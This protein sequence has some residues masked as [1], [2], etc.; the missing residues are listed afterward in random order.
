MNANRKTASTVGALYIIGTVAGILSLVVTEPVRNAEDYLVTIPGN[1]T[2]LAAGAFFVLVM[3]LALAMIP[4]VMFPILKKHNEALALGYVVFRG[5]LEAVG[6]LT[7]ATGWLLLVLVSQIYVQAEVSGASGFEALGTLIFEATAITGGTIMTIVFCLGA[8]MFNYLLY[9]TKL[10]PRWL[11]GWGLIAVVPY[12]ST[13]LLA[14]LGIIPILSPIYTVPQLPLALQEM[15]LAAW[16]IV[17]GFN[18]SAT[19]SGTVE[20]TPNGVQVS[21]AKVKVDTQMKGTNMQ[22]N[23]VSSRL[24]GEGQPIDVRIKLSGLWISTMLVFAYVDLFGFFRADVLEN[25]LAGKVYIFDVSQTFLLL[26]TLYVVIPSVMIVLS[27]IVR[28]PRNRIVNIAASVVYIVTIGLSMVGE[29]WIYFLA[30]SVAEI[31]L[32]LT[33]TYVAWT[34]PR[35]SD[36]TDSEVLF[37]E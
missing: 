10:I 35:A 31:A 13:G 20:T 15:V 3:G 30:G 27:L 25:A 23:S 32:L 28:P 9:R 16:L 19:V 12:L 33:I 7:I 11:S 5:G 4:V 1:E 37:A 6:Y 17:K 8:L 36:A 21:T 34:W 18:P 26:T 22:R 14:M 29:E 2:G 24:E